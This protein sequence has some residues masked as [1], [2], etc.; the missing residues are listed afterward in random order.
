[1]SGTASSI[2]ARRVFT[3]H[4]WL[5]NQ[6]IC[7]SADGLITAIRPLPADDASGEV[8]DGIVCAGLID[9]QLYGAQDTMFSNQPTVECIAATFEEHS[10]AGTVAFQ[11]TLNCVAPETMWRA[12][13]ACAQVRIPSLG[14]GKI[15]SQ[16]TSCQCIFQIFAPF[17]SCVRANRAAQVLHALGLAFFTHSVAC[18][19]SASFA[20]LTIFESKNST[21]SR[22]HSTA[23]AASPVCT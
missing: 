7:I 20:P 17:K 4:E 16:I 11:I 3:G 9:L 12:I 2:R 10:R 21:F 18:S 6:E 8:L 22:A 15:F 23:A 13:D 14:A 19:A 5:D 1:M